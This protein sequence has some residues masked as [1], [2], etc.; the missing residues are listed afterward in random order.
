MLKRVISFICAIG[1]AVFLSPKPAYSYGDNS[2]GTKFSP[3]TGMPSD[4]PY[5]PVLVQAGNTKD[6][7]PI[8]GLSQA[9][10]TYEAIYW[11]PAHTRYLLLFN[12]NHPIEVGSLRSTRL[13][14]NE[15]REMWDCPFVFWGSQGKFSELYDARQFFVDQG[16]GDEF[17]F[18]GLQRTKDD[19]IYR[20]KNMTAPNNAMLNLSLLAEAHWP[21]DKKGQPYEPE[22]PEMLFSDTPSRGSDTAYVV[23]VV[24]EEKEYA[25]RYV[26][27]ND[28]RFY[29]RWY[30]GQ[31]Q[32]DASGEAIIASN[33]IVQYVWQSFYDNDLSLPV[34]KTTGSGPIDVFIDGTHI[35]GNWV[36]DA[37]DTWVRYLDENGNELMLLPGKTFVQM[38]PM[39]TKII[40]EDHMGV[41]HEVGAER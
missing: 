29:L 8:Y 33:I 40:Y 36:R 30:D 22:S 4:L 2:P 12:D 5:R 16:V 18:D 7:R 9:D 34:I 35:R 38:M 20:D 13:F 32:K 6:A 41:L 19:L 10:I 23:D 39:E 28:S 24:Y 11:G 37:V 26:Y 3:T 27:D 25:V 21:T 14:F 17:L 31:P 1:I 15:L